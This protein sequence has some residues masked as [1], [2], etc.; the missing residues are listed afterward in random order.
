MLELQIAIITGGASLSPDLIDMSDSEKDLL[1][2]AAIKSGNE[3]IIE[4]VSESMLDDHNLVDAL[5]SM[6]FGTVTAEEVVNDIRNNL[7]AACESLIQDAI[8]EYNNEVYELL[9]EP[10]RPDS[11]FH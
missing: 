8:D 10:A 4:A 5:D 3:K 6:F 11:D 7:Y 1:V 2:H 9:A